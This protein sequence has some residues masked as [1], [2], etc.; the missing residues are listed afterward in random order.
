MIVVIGE[1]KNVKNI[2]WRKRYVRLMLLII[3]LELMSLNVKLCQR[4]LL[5]FVFVKYVI[6]KRGKMLVA[7]N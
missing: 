6:V 3:G 4:C 1:R 7:N 2:D 5:V